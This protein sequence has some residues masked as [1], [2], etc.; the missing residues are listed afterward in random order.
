MDYE[1]TIRQLAEPTLMPGQ[2]I[3]DIVV[4]ARK[5]PGKVLL[6]VDAD[7]GISIDDC[8]EISRKL[9][10]ALD[11][12][13]FLDEN[14]MLEVS[15]PGVDQPLK[16]SRQYPKHIGRKLKLQLSDKQIEGKLTEVKENSVILIQE[17]GKGKKKEEVALEVTFP[18][19]QKAF[20]LVSFK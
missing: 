16:L 6:T 3:V 12:A 19:I 14:Y 2:F 17:N 9:S 10:K 13:A 18:E 15:T 20:V 5:A 4:S 7:Q 11:E 8:A 1:Q